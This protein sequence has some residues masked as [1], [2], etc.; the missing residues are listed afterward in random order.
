[1]GWFR[2]ARPLSS[3]LQNRYCYQGGLLR[4]G[5]G[6][7]NAEYLSP[8]TDAQHLFYERGHIVSSSR[9]RCFFDLFFI[10]MESY[11]ELN[12]DQRRKIF[13]KQKS[14]EAAR[15]PS[16]WRVLKAAILDGLEGI[17][18]NVLSRIQTGICIV[19]HVQYSDTAWPGSPCIVCL[20]LL[21]PASLT[22]LGCL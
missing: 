17:Q 1:M 6:T 21:L 9:W 18:I 10:S 2:R 20:P 5:T 13:L 11:Q 19:H 8:C 16:T 15:L 7:I 12:V 14:G 4:Y 3:F 22:H